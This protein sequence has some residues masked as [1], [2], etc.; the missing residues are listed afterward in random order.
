MYTNTSH[1]RAKLEF[2]SVMW[3][4]LCTV[5]V[6]SEAAAVYSLVSKEDK[7]WR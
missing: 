7:E 1:P 6:F 2:E 5:Q 3:K 4:G